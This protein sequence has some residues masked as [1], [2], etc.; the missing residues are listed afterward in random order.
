M[1]ERGAWWGKRRKVERVAE[2]ALELGSVSVYAR[3]FGPVGGGVA[4]CIPGLTSNS[5]AFDVIGERLAEAERKA[6]ALDL[7]GRGRSDTTPAGTYGWRRHAQ[8]VLGVGARLS[9]EPFDLVGHS[10]GAFVA[11]QAAVLAPDR[12]RRLV[13]I[14]GAGVPEQAAIGPILRAVERL[15]T[16]HP[17]A[18]DYLADVRRNGAI[19]P[20]SERWERAFVHE[21][22]RVPGGVRPRTHRAA[23]L[24]DVA[25]GARHD[26]RRLW[27]RLR[28]PVLLVRATV[29]LGSPGGFVVSAADRDRLLREVRGASVVEVEA[30]HYGIVMHPATAEASARFLA[31]GPGPGAPR[32][33]RWRPPWAR[34]RPPG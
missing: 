23:V 22:E 19:V 14:D 20:W 1:R 2:L 4:I 9:R 17:S 32:R 18:A 3:R 6:V 31:W 34:H 29:P 25:Y 33:G 8:D 21:L 26:P 15:G 10:M 27:P 7:R 16:V 28:A 24:E 11:M 5:L 13:L 12:V 30:N